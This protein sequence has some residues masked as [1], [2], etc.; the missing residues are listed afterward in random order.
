LAVCRFCKSS[1]PDYAKVCKTCHEPLYW[2]GRLIKSI[3]V[4]TILLALIPTVIAINQYTAKIV[5]ENNELMA[6]QR[7]T[8]TD[9]VAKNIIAD[10]LNEAPRGVGELY[11]QATP[12]SAEF[13]TYQ[14][15]WSEDPWDFESREKIL[16][17]QVSKKV[18]LAPEPEFHEILEGAGMDSGAAAESLEDL[19]REHI[20][21]PGTGSV[22]TILLGSRPMDADIMVN[23]KET[24]YKTPHKLEI[25]SGMHTITLAK[26]TLKGKR[27]IYVKEGKNR[28]VYIILK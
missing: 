7:E 2:W 26:D 19:Y 1:I 24:E 9:S 28:P 22:G 6:R 13:E 16:L 27:Q 11:R 12:S 23:G 15:R 14:R 8:V 18:I 4:L 21:E 10:V 3:P 25:P 20:P 17:Y 5:A